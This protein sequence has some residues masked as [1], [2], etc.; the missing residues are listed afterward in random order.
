MQMEGA[1]GWASGGY[2]TTGGNASVTLFAAGNISVLGGGAA[3]CAN[4]IADSSY[5]T[6]PGAALV[7][8]AAAGNVSLNTGTYLYSEG[9]LGIGGASVLMNNAFAF[10]KG[11]T[12]VTATGNLDVLN[13]SQLRSDYLMNIGTGGNVLVDSSSVYGYPDV[14]LTVGGNINMNNGG[15]IE[16]GSLTTI[17]AFF[18]MLVSGGYF[19]NGIE[20]VVY[21]SLTSTGFMA[22]SSG[23]ILG[24]NLLVTYGGVQNVPTD[25]LIVAM[26]ES[27]KPPDPDKNKDIFQ[28]VEDEKK[29]VPVCR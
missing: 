6:T 28:E 13:G 20:G 19:V 3:C 21:D 14:S 18:P 25:A 23:A 16:A 1:E 24:T 9:G 10:S 27:T 12:I 11:G 7:L 15:T 22:G 5:G 17:Y 29:D 26:G 2:G 4:L 8:L